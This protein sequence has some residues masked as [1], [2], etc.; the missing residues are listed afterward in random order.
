MDGGGGVSLRIF[1]TWGG[2][3]VLVPYGDNWP[4]GVSQIVSL[5]FF[6]YILHLELLVQI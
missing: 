5:S 3:P 1:L 6:W 2:H 4:H